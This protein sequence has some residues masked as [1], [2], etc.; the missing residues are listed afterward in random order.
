L[1][2]AQYTSKR[3]P[4]GSLVGAFKIVSTKRINELRLTPSAAV[5]QRNYYEHIIGDEESL[6]RIRGYID[7]NVVRW[8]EDQLNPA[9]PSKW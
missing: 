5:W 2:P 8:A 9:S 1:K 7:E 4:L 6:R 3:K